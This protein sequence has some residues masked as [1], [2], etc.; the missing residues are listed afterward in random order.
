MFTCYSKAVDSIFSMSAPSTGFA[1]DLSEEIKGPPQF[2]SSYILRLSFDQQKTQEVRKR[3]LLAANHRDD[4]FVATDYS[5]KVSAECCSYL[6]ENAFGMSI[7]C[8]FQ[9]V[10][11]TDRITL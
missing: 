3:N 2:L 6:I 9:C 10:H 7:E 5:R 11:W 1:Q 4:V 8:V